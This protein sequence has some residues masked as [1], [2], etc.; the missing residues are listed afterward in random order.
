[1]NPNGEL[2]PAYKVSVDNVVTSLALQSDG[3]IIVGG[4]FS[5]IGG[6]ARNGIAR[7]KESALSFHSTS[8]FSGHFVAQLDGEAGKTYVIESSPDLKTWNPFT[9]NV[10][11][12]TGLTIMDEA[13]PTQKRRFF[14][15]KL[16]E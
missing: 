13:A 2:D 4:G 6:V 1:M 5:A 3:K 16:K 9:T 10:A 15:A 14:R 7:L 12:E 11:T 8:N